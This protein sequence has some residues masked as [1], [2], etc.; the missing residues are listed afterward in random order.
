VLAVD[1]NEIVVSPP[2]SPSSQLKFRRQDGLRQLAAVTAP[3]TITLSESERDLV[4]VV[5]GYMNDK[6]EVSAT[7]DRLLAMIGRPAHDDE[8]I[9]LDT[10][11]ML[12]DALIVRG[13]ELRFDRSS[14]HVVLGHVWGGCSRRDTLISGTTKPAAVAEAVAIVP[15]S[16]ADDEA[17][18]ARFKQAAEDVFGR[19][20][21]V[22]RRAP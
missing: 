18:I 1:G 21:E 15:S 22:R 16:P 19:G 13:I 20:I 12:A 6:V 3:A 2:W 11:M 5:V 10:V 7:P 17:A 8:A 14:G 9:P 4:E